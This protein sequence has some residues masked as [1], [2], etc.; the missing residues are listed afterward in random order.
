MRRIPE[1]K[2]V[3][4]SKPRYYPL[5][6][7][8]WSHEPK[9]R[10]AHRLPLQYL[11]LIDQLRNNSLRN[12]FPIQTNAR[13]YNLPIFQ[14]SFSASTIIAS[15]VNCLHF[16]TS[17]LAQVTVFVKKGENPVGIIAPGTLS[18]R[19]LQLSTPAMAEYGYDGTLSFCFLPL[20]HAPDRI[21]YSCRQ[22]R[23][24]RI[25]N[26]SVLLRLTTDKDIAIG[27]ALYTRRLSDGKRPVLLRMKICTPMGI[28]LCQ[29]CR[30]YAFP[31][32]PS[33]S[34]CVI[35]FPCFSHSLGQEP[36][37]YIRP[38]SS[39]LYMPH[40]LDIDRTQPWCFMISH[41]IT[42]NAHPSLVLTERIR[43]VR[44]DLVPFF[45]VF[46]R[47]QIDNRFSKRDKSGICLGARFFQY[48]FPIEFCCKIRP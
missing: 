13:F 43:K 32:W 38:V 19:E 23:R 37:R 7:G 18:L 45:S 34:L 3:R 14:K 35:R 21:S 5:K 41:P 31:V 39:R 8:F 4:T 6:D 22:H 25:S 26:L 30:R 29:D 17:K 46:Q 27:N 20:Q 10:T 15:S 48:F 42:S 2:I 44:L 36:L 9:T 40:T 33:G 47:R 28:T 24:H 16:D 1:R 12:I 11:P